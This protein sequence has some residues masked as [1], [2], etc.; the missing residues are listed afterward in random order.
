MEAAERRNL[1]CVWVTGGRA[2]TEQ[3]A[4]VEIVSEARLLLREDLAQLGVKWD[5]AAL[6]PGCPSTC[7][8]DDHRSGDSD[9]SSVSCISPHDVQTDGTTE[10]KKSRVTEVHREEITREDNSERRMV[11]KKDGEEENTRNQETTEPKIRQTNSEFLDERDKENPKTRT[12]KSIV[13]NKENTKENKKKEGLKQEECNTIRPKAGETSKR[14]ASIRPEKSDYDAAER[15]LTQELDEIVSSPL[16]HMPPPLQP[17]LSPVAPPCFRAPI[18]CLEQPQSVS[19]STEQ[20]ESLT[21]LTVSPLHP[22][23]LKHS[24][25][26]SKV[27]Q[28]IQTS[29]GP[30]ENVE[31]AERSD[32]ETATSAPAPVQENPSA[33]ST[34][35]HA[36]MIN[37]PLSVSP[38]FVPRFTPEA[39]RRRIDARDVDKFSS[40]ELY[41]GNKTDEEAEEEVNMEGES[42]G[43]SFNLDTQTERIIAQ[44]TYRDEGKDQL[45]ETQ[46]GRDEETVIADVELA[47]TTD[48]RRN[49][50]EDFNIACP[51]F[52]TSFTDS[53]LELILNTSHHVSD[54]NNV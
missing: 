14:S 51:R 13:S 25:A 12:N 40:P 26:L 30:Q 2:L 34:P 11:D 4:A 35:T 45:V 16:P 10:S 53:Q 50:L 18:S 3:E 20:E 41:A 31:D 22:G 7:S 48:G 49:E 15:N 47:G 5:P 54:F 8:P 33:V 36:D 42:F 9:T 1:R 38:A 29:K 24:R 44:Q 39:K 43:D 52:S 19:T 37:S 27:L 21:K 6:P 28:S 17:L 46:A 32:L 23:R